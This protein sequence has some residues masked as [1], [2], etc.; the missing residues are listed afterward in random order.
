MKVVLFYRHE[1][2]RMIELREI[3]SSR[4]EAWQIYPVREQLGKVKSMDEAKDEFITDGF[5]LDDQSFS[6]PCPKCDHPNAPMSLDTGHY[7]C[8]ECN[9]IF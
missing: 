3:S 9:A 4:V 2:G 5:A 1:D 6:P 8:P 7:T